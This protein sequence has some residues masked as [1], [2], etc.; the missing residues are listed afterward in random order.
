M[1]AMFLVSSNSRGG[2]DEHMKTLEDSLSSAA[3]AIGVGVAA[4]DSAGR[5]LRRQATLSDVL[6]LPFVVDR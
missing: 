6:A 1:V 2:A 3:S 5:G 4:E